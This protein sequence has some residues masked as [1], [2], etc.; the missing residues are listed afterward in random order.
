MITEYKTLQG[1]SQGE[2]KDKGS[3]FIAVAVPAYTEEDVKNLIST[4]RKEHPKNRHI[5]CAFSIG[6]DH[7]L[8]R[9]N[10]DGEPAGTAGKPILGQ[11]HSFGLNNLAVAVVRYF[12]G[13]LLGVPGLIKA[14]K[15]AS[16]EA[17]NNATIIQKHIAAVYE[18]E[19]DYAK[20]H[21]VMNY[22]KREAVNVLGQ[23]TKDSCIILLSIEPTLEGKL[24]SDL[25]NKFGIIA[26]FKYYA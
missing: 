26:N 7:P 5:C 16:I 24:K 6:T 11:I 3:K 4:L 13:T 17:L 8:E 1:P 15:T 12:G 23:E 14:Y 9:S 22:L 10:D 25:E 18:V 21:E 19:T 2:Y 20:F